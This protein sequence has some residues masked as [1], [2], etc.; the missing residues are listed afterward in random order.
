[1]RRW[2][3]ETKYIVG[4]ILHNVFIEHVDKYNWL[5]EKYLVLF[6]KKNCAFIYF[7]NKDH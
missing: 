7:L 5:I 2:Q 6:E 3:R 4:V 1:M